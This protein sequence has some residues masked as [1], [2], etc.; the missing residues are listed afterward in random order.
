MAAAGFFIAH[1]GL[2]CHRLRTFPLA[3]GVA[4]VRNP[5]SRAAAGTGQDEEPPMPVDEL[6]EAA[7]FGH[8]A[9]HRGKASH[10]MLT[11]ALALRSF[12][13]SIVARSP[14]HRLYGH[15]LRM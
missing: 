14:S 9:N 2:I 15:G 1:E 5:R 3:I 13:P 12:V 7:A 11:F 4:I 6:L 8:E 10:S